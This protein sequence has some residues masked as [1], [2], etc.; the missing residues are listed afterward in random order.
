M[1]NL[2]SY[3]FYFRI[4]LSFCQIASGIKEI[5]P[6]KSG[7]KFGKIAP[8]RLWRKPNNFPDFRCYT[9]DEPHI[10]KINYSQGGAKAQRPP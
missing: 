5:F 7:R 10:I 3:F 9:T 2:I 6:E 4:N 1:F 8:V